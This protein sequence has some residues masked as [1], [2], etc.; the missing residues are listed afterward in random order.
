MSIR[1]IAR[2]TGLSIGA[3]LALCATLAARSNAPPPRLDRGPP[4]AAA[5]VVLSRRLATNHAT[6]QRRPRFRLR[7][8]RDNG[9]RDESRARAK[10]L[11]S[12]RGEHSR[13]SREPAAALRRARL[14]RPLLHPARGPQPEPAAATRCERRAD[15]PAELVDRRMSHR[16]RRDAARPFELRRPH[17]AREDPLGD[18]HVGLPRRAAGREARGRQ[19]VRRRLR[20][21]RIVGEFHAVSRVGVRARV[22]ALAAARHLA[23]RDRRANVGVAR[24]PAESTRSASRTCCPAA[25]TAG[26]GS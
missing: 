5:A 21:R 10:T 9:R 14:G 16:R 19:L 7:G 13:L 11:R 23:R 4:P 2:W 12:R 18:A 3:A 24:P 6:R 20:R 22:R 25:A 15:G 1:R 26:A 17:G 8:R